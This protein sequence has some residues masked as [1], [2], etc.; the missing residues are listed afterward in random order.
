MSAS[1]S[2]PSARHNDAVG[3]DGDRLRQVTWLASPQAAEPRQQA[4]DLLS[5][6]DPLV[7]ATRLRQALPELPVELAAAC[8]EQAALA[9]Q[10]ADRYGIEAY[11]LLTRDGLEA[12][13]RPEVASRRAAL[14]AGSGARRVVD[15]TGGLGFDTSA[16]LAAGLAVTAVERDPAIAVALAHNCPSATVVNGEATAVLPDLLPTLGPEDV[17]FVDPARRDPLGPRDARTARARP[18]RDPERWSPSWS[19]VAGIPHP[20]V[21]AKVSPGFAPPPTWQAEWVSVDRALVEC[22]V[23]SWPLLTSSR[24]AVVFTGDRSLDMPAD[25]AALPVAHSLGTWLAEPD[26]AV[27]RA[28]AL[29]ALAAQEGLMSAGARSTWLTGDHAPASH[30]L[31]GFQVVA[32]LTGSTKQQR[33]ALADLGIARL[34]V[35]S[36]DVEVEPASVL[37]A[38]G[39]SEGGR[40]VLVVTRRDDHV[41]SVVTEPAPAR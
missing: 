27:L 23:Y 2:G 35:K 28:G 21:A 20:R 5:A 11:L 7:A 40:H 8:L 3:D 32:E 16:F 15:L 9:R 4:R 38:L 1:R 37:R 12:A 6:H 22:A 18:E 30:V 13:T 25:D 29:P 34:T 19:F 17:V 39:V 26:P 33:R 31:R 36:R 14:I 24:Q 41:V 10:A